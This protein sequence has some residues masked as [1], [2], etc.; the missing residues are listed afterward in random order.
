MAERSRRQSEAAREIGDLPKVAHPRRRKKC[1][2]N[3]LAFCESYFPERFDIPWSPDHLKAIAKI[4]QAV[5][6]GGLF[7]LAMPRGSGKTALCVV[8]CIWGVLYA[9][10]MFYVLVGVDVSL[11]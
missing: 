5:L 10:R 11:Y 8:A 2:R 3:F 6:R 9:H 7:A 4:E 1:E